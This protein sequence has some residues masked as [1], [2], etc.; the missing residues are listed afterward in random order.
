MSRLV[1]GADGT[2]RCS[3]APSYLQLMV[4]APT[5]TSGPTTVPLT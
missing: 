1:T 3:W 4:P 2:V 5:L